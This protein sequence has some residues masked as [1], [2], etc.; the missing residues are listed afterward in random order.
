[1]AICLKY[2]SKS[3]VDFFNNHW[4]VESHY[5]EIQGLLW[6]ITTDSEKLFPLWDLNRVLLPLESDAISH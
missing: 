2:D 3:Q 1:M 5:L 6:V 4:V